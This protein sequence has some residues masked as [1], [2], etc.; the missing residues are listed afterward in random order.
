MLLQCIIKSSSTVTVIT[1]FNK[2]K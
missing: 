1:V 2:V